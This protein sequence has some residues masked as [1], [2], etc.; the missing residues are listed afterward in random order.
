[1]SGLVPCHGGIGLECEGL[2]E[3]ISEVFSG[4]FEIFTSFSKSFVGIVN[5]VFSGILNI[6][7]EVFSGILNIIT[8]VFIILESFVGCLVLDDLYGLL[9]SFPFVGDACSGNDGSF[10]G[11][12]DVCPLVRGERVDTDA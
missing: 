10:N 9:S 11:I 8:P 7:N 12:L 5:K 1:V 6:I 4:L 2:C 3:G